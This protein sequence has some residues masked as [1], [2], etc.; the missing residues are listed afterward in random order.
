MHLL[1]IPAQSPAIVDFHD[2]TS[3]FIG[4][5]VIANLE[6]SLNK[7]MKTKQIFLLAVGMVACALWSAHAQNISMFT[8]YDD[9]TNWNNTNTLIKF[10]ATN[11]LD[12]DGVTVNGIG[13][14]S[15]GATS[16][17]G[18]L[19]VSPILPCNWGTNGPVFNGPGVTAAGLA[20]IDGPAAA[21]GS[22]PLA[23]SGTMY[24]DFTMPDHNTNGTSFGIGV[25]MQCDGEWGLGGAD[26]SPTD[27]GPVSTPSGTQEKYR[28]TIP[29]TIN[30]VT[31]NLSY[32]A[33]GFWIFTDYVGTNSWYIDN[34]S[35][36]PIP[37]TIIP[38]PVQPLFN[39]YDDFNTGWTASGGDLIQA[40]NAWSMDGSTTNGLGNT[41]APGATGAAS[42]S[43]LVYWSSIETA[44]GTIAAGPVEQD[45][46]AF[47]QAIAPG[48]DV[49]TLA[50]PGAYGNIY[51]NY[52]QPDNS[53][54]GSYFQI[55]M[56]FSYAG[57]GYTYWNNS[58]FFPSKT[59]DLNMQ[60][61]NGYEVYQATI[62]YNIQ[63]GYLYGFTPYVFVNSDYQPTNGFHIDNISVSSAPMPILSAS[64]DGANL[65]IQGTNGLTGRK[66]N[67]LSTTNLALPVTNW[68]S[69][70]VGVPFNGPTF[71]TTNNAASP[72]SFYTIKVQ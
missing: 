2:M 18:S 25:F 37:T 56:A 26:A 15:S 31:N 13:N 49:N 69:V 38:A 63:A 11:A 62:P 5:I 68:A 20:A 42:G 55:G 27:L 32:F 51:M 53:E 41:N 72:A 23:Q 65:V 9:W 36:A 16:L 19:Q 10:Q 61:S 35:V 44:F 24:L 46:P 21:F 1:S 34:L 58:I 67:L 3:M 4:H 6:Q 7:P 12:L 39:T 22:P 50:S 43:L 40:D 17:G 64:M 33:L 66:Y 14:A 30:A 28:A 59:T 57:N 60:D 52:S 45:N 54:G 47:L 71:S 70:S 8:T 29:Y 48:Y